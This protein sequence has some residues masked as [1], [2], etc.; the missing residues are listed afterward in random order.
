MADVPTAEELSDLIGQIYAAALNPDEWD[1]LLPN[2]ARAFG[3]NQALLLNVDRD[4]GPCGLLH[5]LNMDLG[6]VAQWEGSKEHDD[7]WYQGIQGIHTDMVYQG[8]DLCPTRRLRASPFYVDSL[9]HL[10]IEHTLGGIS[11][12]SRMR[13]WVFAIYHD[14][15]SGP[16][17]ER[18]K[19]IYALLIPHFGVALRTSRLLGRL[20]AE[21]ES[22][23]ASLNHSPYAVLIFDEHGSIRWMNQNSEAVAFECDGLTIRYGRLSFWDFGTETQF[24][25]LLHETSKAVRIGAVRKSRLL[26]VPRPSGKSEYQIMLSPLSLRPDLPGASSSGACMVMIHDPSTPKEISA[27]LL[28]RLYELTSAEAHVCVAL[29]EFGSLSDAQI[30]TREGPVFGAFETSERP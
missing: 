8:R 19:K 21:R 5:T 13:N 22:L 4:P 26:R 16:F 18:Q 7:P 20:A 28:E 29:F 3:S 6:V 23:A 17:S 15:A 11:C 24:Y 10:D 9:R 25:A 14:E 1:L 30:I 2:L 12:E 27:D